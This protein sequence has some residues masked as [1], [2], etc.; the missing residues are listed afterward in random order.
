MPCKSQTI[1]WKKQDIEIYEKIKKAC[2]KYVYISDE[3]NKEC[4][5]KRNRHLVQNSGYSICYL[6][7]NYG[8][9]AYTVEYARN[10]GLKIINIA[11]KMNKS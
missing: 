4:M 3:Y 2:D 10:N 11:D 6:T 1:A 5:H 7:R 8:G 9:T